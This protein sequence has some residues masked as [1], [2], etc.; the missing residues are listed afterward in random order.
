[1]KTQFIIVSSDA[2]DIIKAERGELIVLNY[3]STVIIDGEPYKTTGEAELNL[4]KD[5]LKIRIWKNPARD[6]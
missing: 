6:R 2:S 5:I 1:M 3:N 4:D